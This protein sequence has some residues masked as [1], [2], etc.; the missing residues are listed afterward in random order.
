MSNIEVKFSGGVV[1]DPEDF[2]FADGGKVRNIP[3]YVNDQDKQPDGSYADNGTVTKIRVR[4]F[5]DLAETDIRKGDIVE[6]TGTLVERE[7]DKKDGTKG[8]SLETKF[9][10]SIVVKWR[11][12]G[13]AAPVATDAFATAAAGG[14]PWA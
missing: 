1:A 8:R 12:D 13:G 5:K 11:K 14:D 7:F 4:L 6:V 10:N 3:V 9:V 2:S